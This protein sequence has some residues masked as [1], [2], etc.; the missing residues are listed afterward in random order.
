[1]EASSAANAPYDL[2]LRNA[3]IIDGTDNPWY[4]ADIGIRGEPTVVIGDLSDALTSDDHSAL[5]GLLT[6]GIT[7]VLI[8]PDGRDEFNYSIGLEAAVE[9][10]IEVGRQ[11]G[12]PVVVTLCSPIASL[13]IR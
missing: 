9:E 2:V 3:Q 7:T 13:G 4:R 10:V 11:A 12:I 5:P 8:N 6:Q 1:L